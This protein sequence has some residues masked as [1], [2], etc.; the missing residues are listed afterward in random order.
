MSRY[1]HVLGTQRA[2]SSPQPATLGLVIVCG[3]SCAW[4]GI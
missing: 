3:L 1:S 2:V 4:Q